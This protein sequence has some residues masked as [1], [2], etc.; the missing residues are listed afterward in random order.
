MS[1]RG[2]RRCHTSI[3]LPKTRSPQ[4]KEQVARRRFGLD[5]LFLLLVILY[6]VVPL[7]ATFAFGFESGNNV[8]QQIF[9]DPDLT[10]TLLL[11]LGLALSATL[12]A[13]ILVTPTA[14]WVQLHLPQARP[15]MDFLS[16]V[17]FAVPAI[18]MSLGLLEVYGTPNTLINILSLGLVPILSNPPFTLV[19]SPPLL[20]CAYVIVSL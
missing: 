4:G 13:I 10:S 8:L 2:N 15:L 12:L 1:G 16:L 17:P 14:Y 9:T 18:V 6:L 19:N 20:A 5:A 3:A 11:S 7:G